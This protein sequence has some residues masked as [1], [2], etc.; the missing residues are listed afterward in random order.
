MPRR[1]RRARGA[2]LPPRD[3]ALRGVLHRPV[4]TLGRG[5]G[6]GEA[7]PLSAS[8]SSVAPPL[9]LRRRRRQKGTVART[10]GGARRAVPGQ[11]PGPQGRGADD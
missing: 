9:L 3:P 2:P 6:G 4:E 7:A 5:R 10:P 8:A 11:A 1:R